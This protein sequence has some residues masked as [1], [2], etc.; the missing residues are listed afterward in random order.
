MIE[1]KAAAAI[2][3]KEINET[4]R[5]FY[6]AKI[7]NDIN[8]AG[9]YFSKLY[10][11]ATENSCLNRKLRSVLAGWEISEYDAEVFI[12]EYFCK[13]AKNYDY[14]KNDNF[15]AFLLEFIW[16]SLNKK[17]KN[18]SKKPPSISLD[19]YLTDDDGNINSNALEKLGAENPFEE[20]ETV[21]KVRSRLPALITCFYKHNKGKQASKTRYDYFRIFNTEN[22]IECI[23]S[24]GNTKYFNKAETYESTDRDFVRFITN[25][26][27]EKLDDLLSFEFKR[28]SE[29]LEDYTYEDK[30]ITIPC[31]GKIISEYCYKSGK[32]EKRPTKENISQ[33]RKKYENYF[34]EI[35]LKEV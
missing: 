35:W 30:E 21:I 5:K 10:R 14:T 13:Q 20:D 24:S 31:E 7:S 32:S 28:F 34:K 17:R 6:E 16:Q 4:A 29:V 2:T 18:D 23:N 9:H 27:Y 26:S 22:I 1:D 15:V 11:I 3:E 19:E 12:S 8:E 33:F 25:S